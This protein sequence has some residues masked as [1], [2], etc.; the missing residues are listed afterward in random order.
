MKIKLF[1]V[2]VLA[3]FLVSGCEEKNPSI[4]TTVYP[5]QYLVER[6]GGDDVTVSNITENTMIQRAQ[7]KSSFQD[8]LKN[9]DA[10]FYIGG[11]EPYMDLYVDDIRDTGVDMVD[12]ATKSAIYKFERYTSTTI[13]GI[14]AGTE[15]PYYEGEEFANLDTYDADPMLWMDP[16]A[17]TSMASDIRDYLVQKYPQYKDIF[18]ENYD[19]LELDLARL[20][21]DFQAIPDGKM[22]ISFVSMT[23]SFGNWQKSY[24]IKVYPVTLS[25]YGAL[26]T[27]D[28]LAAI[29]KRIKS[30]HVRYIA[31]EQ[32]LSED[33][34][35]LQQQLIDEL[36]LIPVNLN[37]LS[38]ISSE[39][40]KASKD[41]LTI[42]YDNL[43]A[44]ESIAS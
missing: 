32:N 31:I 8:I 14:T 21:A 9:S 29:K 42:M 26:P 35:K 23:P 4:A 17:M 5:V 40:K 37:N 38:S 28:Q 22:N 36:A 34:E 25:K 44:L 16:V 20:E 6:I 27:S 15:G 19:A 11:L 7:I 18:D 41:Y 3:L 1:L 2:S 10:L 13:D 12:L 24:G 30:D 43:K 33:M 39:D